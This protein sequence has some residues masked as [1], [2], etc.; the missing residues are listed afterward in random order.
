MRALY[1]DKDEYSKGAPVSRGICRMTFYLGMSVRRAFEIVQS[2][3]RLIRGRL[4]GP[5][6]SIMKRGSDHRR[7]KI[8]DRLRSMASRLSSIENSLTRSAPSGSRSKHLER[9][10]RYGYDQSQNTLLEALGDPDPGVRK[11]AL[12]SMDDIVGE[13]LTL[14][15]VD[16][17]NDPDPQVRHAAIR[18]IEKRNVSSAVFSLI[19]LLADPVP[20]VAQGAAH[21][22]WKITGKK[23]K[24]DANASDASRRKRMEKLKAW[25]KEE[26]FADLAK[27]VKLEM[28]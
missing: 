25:W 10:R 24:L 11:F 23:V 28:N 17:L 21:A 15:L 14:L 22:I 27:E 16:S 9:E 7:R 13:D 26:R 3:Y 20:E 6:S 4:G 12:G 19:L 8:S 2:P 18:A 5:G 1:L